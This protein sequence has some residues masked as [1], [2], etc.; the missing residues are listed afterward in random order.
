MIIEIFPQAFMEIMTRLDLFLWVLGGTV[1]GIMLGILPG[2]GA[3]MALAVLLP[4]TYS[5]EPLIAISFLLAVYSASAF[6]G[7]I[8]AILMGIPGTAQAIATQLDGYP[9]MKQGRGGEALTY[10]TMG[11]AIGGVLGVCMLFLFAPI[12][13]G[14]AYNLQSAEYA[15]LAI[16]ALVLMAYVGSGSILLGIVSGVAGLLIGTVGMDAM[17]F[18]PRLDFGIRELRVGIDIVP[19]IVGVFGLAEVFRNL[20]EMR[21]PKAGPPVMAPI[22][23]IYPPMKEFIGTI[24]ASLRGGLIGTF[25]GAL[26]AVGTPVAV[27]VAYAQEKQISKTPERFGKGAP[28]SIMSVESCNNAAVGGALIPTFTLGI[29]GNPVVAILLG[30]LII[31][32]MTPGPRLLRDEPLFFGT[33]FLTLAVSIILTTVI[34]QLTIRYLVLIVRVPERILIPLIVVL[35]I[36]GSYSV[37]NSVFNVWIMI[38]FG[39]VGFAMSIARISPAPLIFG[40]ILGPILEVNVRRTLMVSGGDPSI[41]VTRPISLTILLI[42]ALALVWPLVSA[43]RRGKGK[44]K[45]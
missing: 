23:R 16:F 30:A 35:T 11:S 40:V 9:M 39:I 15:A 4:L 13:A 21:D 19:V 18:T 44:V 45:S 10:A 32:G 26:P 31:H 38:V 3:V 36:I 24:P 34:I 41:F 1:V 17:T 42:A 25:M 7:A 12:I 2:V 43:W 37:A 22:S 27:A 28:E 6:G 14:L 20:A 33:T 8:P 29:P 5:L